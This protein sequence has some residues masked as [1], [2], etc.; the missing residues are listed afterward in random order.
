[1]AGPLKNLL[2][3][4][5]CMALIVDQL[6]RHDAYRKAGGKGDPRKQSYRILSQY[7]EVKERIEELKAELHERRM[8]KAIYSREDV[9]YGLLR[10]IQ[11]ARSGFKVWQDKVVEDPE[12]G[13]PM[14]LVDHRAVNQAYQLLGM[15]IGMFPKQATLT[16]QKA[17][18][19]EG[20][21]VPEMLEHVRLA[22]LE[23][24]DGAVQLD[25]DQLFA[26]IAG[27]EGPN[28]SP[29]AHEDHGAADRTLPAVSETAPLPSGGEGSPRAGDAGGEPAWEDDEWWGGGGLSPDGPLSEVVE[30][31]PL[32]GSDPH[33]GLGADEPED[34]GCG[35]DEAPGEAGP[36]WDGDDPE[37]VDRG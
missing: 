35:A 29:A 21:T 14:R 32:P 10:N 37:G 5:F 2:H 11:E 16:H 9:I 23:A 4:R 8:K 22:V 30:G 6:H 1:M 31:P 13:E 3:E 25:V 7:P 20:L 12:T 18:P 19:L 17:A 36:L 26:A 27:G 34:P 28:G 24:S 33:V 15:E